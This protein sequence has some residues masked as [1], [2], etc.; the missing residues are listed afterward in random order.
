MVVGCGAASSSSSGGGGGYSG[1][2]K[3]TTSRVHECEHQSG[4]HEG[5]KSGNRRFVFNPRYGLNDQ[6]KGKA[7][8][9]KHAYGKED[10]SS[11]DKQLGGFHIRVHN[12]KHSGPS[13][14]WLKMH[15]FSYHPQLLAYLTK[16]PGNFLH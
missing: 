7:E 4:E 5:E 12:P 11:F 8:V 15:P 1:A 9:V 6:A 2:A 14:L 3:P 16:K 10:V 13:W